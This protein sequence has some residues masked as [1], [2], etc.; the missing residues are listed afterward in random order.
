MAIISKDHHNHHHRHH[1]HTTIYTTQ[2]N[3]ILQLI[4]K[5]HELATVVILQKII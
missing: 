1:T 2:I 5:H 3:A 4:H